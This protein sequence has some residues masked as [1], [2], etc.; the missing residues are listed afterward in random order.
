MLR[1]GSPPE[2]ERLRVVQLI[3]TLKT[4]GLEHVS[5]T[6]AAALAP[7]VERVVVCTA[8]GPAYEGRLRE[9][10]IETLQVSRPNP[11]TLRRIARTA[12]ELAPVLRRERPHVVHAHN[13]AAALAAA[14]ARRLARARGVALVAT[15]HG[16]APARLR[17]ARRVFAAGTDVVVGIGPAATAALREAGLAAER[18]ATVFNAVE[19]VATRAP[20]AVRAEFG[21]GSAELV[22]AVGRYVPE[23]NHALLLDALALLA[24]RRPSL[25]ALVVGFGRLEAD[26]RARIS[27]L[28]LEDVVTLTGAREDAVDLAGAADV[29]VLSSAQEALGLALIEAMTLERPVVATRVGGIV[30]L[31]DDGR[32]GILVPPGDAQAL[33]AAIERLLDDRGLSGRLAAAA[34][35]DARERFAVSTMVA[36]YLDVYRRAVARRLASRAA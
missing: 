15:Y 20:D 24:P 8:G 27:E 9:A 10:G 29:F 35:A 21:L 34:A 11:P 30:D 4:G 25:R 1:A 22:V 6:L 2:D 16:V 36:G 7:L 19:V 28:G 13:P 14:L 5:T 31:V 33:A 18:S 32:T 17:L 23:K 12:W 3:P 26:L